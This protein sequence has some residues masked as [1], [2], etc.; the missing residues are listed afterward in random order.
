MPMNTSTLCATPD[1]HPVTFRTFARECSIYGEDQ[2]HRNIFS[3]AEESAALVGYKAPIA[4]LVNE[5]KTL[6]GGTFH[7]EY[8]NKIYE[9]I[10]DRII[11]ADKP[12]SMA[13][14]SKMEG[15]AK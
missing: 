12:L 4:D 1:S 9:T 13:E 14:L 8:M 11:D 7:G 15:V 3:F 5:V 6:L 10:L 2:A